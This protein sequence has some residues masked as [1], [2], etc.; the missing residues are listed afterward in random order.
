MDRGLHV[1]GVLDHM[2]SIIADKS[3]EKH[4]TS[5]QG[6]PFPSTLDSSLHRAAH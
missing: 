6:R 1:I 5:K 4:L 3:E 2:L